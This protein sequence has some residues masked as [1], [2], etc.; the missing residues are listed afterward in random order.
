VICR[1]ARH[2][3]SELRDGCLSAAERR[4]IAA[5]LESCPACAAEW[6]AYASALDGLSDLARLECSGEIAARVF[7]RLDMENRKPGLAM[8]FRPIRAARPLFLPSLMGSAMLLATALGVTLVLE[9]RHDA[10][11]PIAQQR[12]LDAWTTLPSPV[13]DWGTE[14]DPLFLSEDVTTPRPRHGAEV[15]AYLLEPGAEG[16]VFVETVVARDGT[17]SAVRLVNGD[18][19][20]AEPLLEALR[21]QRFEP[22]RYRGRPVAVSVY[23]LISRMEVR[24]PLT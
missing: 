23:Q 24:A 12:Q 9:D 13:P 22:S 14:S 8:L 7:D 21:R 6:R 17:V 2:R 18:S 4:A 1:L 16:T 20:A 11:P 3:F 19:S 5:H 10:L 15:P